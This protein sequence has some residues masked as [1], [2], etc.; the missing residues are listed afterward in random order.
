M[1]Q[2]IFIV[3]KIQNIFEVKIKFSG[4][5]KIRNYLGQFANLYDRV[6][7]EL[8]FGQMSKYT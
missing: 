4:K 1:F 8:T 2:S 7:F 6:P 3:F 5:I